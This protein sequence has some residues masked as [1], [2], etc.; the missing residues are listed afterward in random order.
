[1][2]T[3]VTV[4][5]KI[6]NLFVVDADL[7]AFIM[8]HFD[9]VWRSISRG[10]SR[11]EKINLLLSL[12]DPTDIDVHLI[13]ITEQ[14]RSAT[15]GTAELPPS[16]SAPL[17]REISR[18]Q[19]VIRDL[20]QQLSSQKSEPVIHPRNGL[21]RL[22][23]CIAQIDALMLDANPPQQATDEEKWIT[24]AHT[25]L[26]ALESSLGKFHTLSSEFRMMFSYERQPF[27]KKYRS[28][29]TAASD[30]LTRQV[31]ESDR[32]SK[33]WAQTMSS[34]NSGRRGG[35]FSW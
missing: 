14:E 35:G 6:N 8:D 10:M 19:H 29:I 21:E 26:D 22:T 17:R 28:L 4:R 9:E 3:R 5:K 1:M 13:S 2:T 7:D 33:S 25:V 23:K 16:D 34:L 11:Q 30:I 20:E 32:E 31:E 15:S 27:S 24:L 18:L 12:K